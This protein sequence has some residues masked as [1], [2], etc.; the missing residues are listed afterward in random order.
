MVGVEGVTEQ[1][2]LDRGLRR[3]IKLGRAEQA[4]RGIVPDELPVLAPGG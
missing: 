1:A 4:D 3:Q 2:L